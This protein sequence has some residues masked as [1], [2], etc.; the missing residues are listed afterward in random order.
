MLE[1]LYIEL[2]RNTMNQLGYIHKYKQIP[3]VKKW[4][5]LNISMYFPQVS[6]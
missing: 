6:N 2:E 4:Y 3:I 5:F 1:Y